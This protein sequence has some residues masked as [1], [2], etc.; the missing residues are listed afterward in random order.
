M[1]N[2]RS[3][4]VLVYS[5]QF[6]NIM[7]ESSTVSTSSQEAQIPDESQP[8][9][10]SA[11]LGEC[12]LRITGPGLKWEK[13]DDCSTAYADPTGKPGGQGSQGLKGKQ[14]IQ[15]PPGLKGEPGL[16][17]VLG[18]QGPRG[19]EGEKG[20]EGPI[21]EDGSEGEKGDRGYTGFKGVKGD[22]GASIPGLQGPPGSPGPYNFYS[23]LS[24]VESPKND[25][26]NDVPESEARNRFP[27][28]Q[29]NPV[30][31]CANIEADGITDAEYYVNPES[32]FSVEC[33]F[34]KQSACLNL[35]N[36]EEPKLC[37]RKPC[38]LF[39]SGFDIVNF[40]NDQ[41]QNVK[42]LSTLKGLTHSV[43]KISIFCKYLR[44][45][46]KSN[47]QIQLYH[48]LLI[49]PEATNETPLYYKVN[50]DDC[51]SEN[52]EGYAEIEITIN[53]PFL[54]ITDFYIKDFNKE[55]KLIFESNEVCFYY[56]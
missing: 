36:N 20:D 32:K 33:N 53:G 23:H 15:G 7:A 29:K 6:I 16:S 11:E 37:D 48:M 40:Y 39:K 47:L 3:F 30:K 49:G 42:Y 52:H 24:H 56:K 25:V 4:V 22:Q 43:H 5:L 41:L 14:S 12:G 45:S 21:G 28:D 51:T 19:L 55:S 1:V 8:Q 34:I 17:G 13:V 54:P 35:K 10:I 27:G 9:K 2:V 26:G 38:W 46:E 18:V 31:S 44:L 50:S